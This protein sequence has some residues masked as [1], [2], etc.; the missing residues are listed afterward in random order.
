[1]ICYDD[2]SDEHEL[3]MVG[4][5]D[6]KQFQ[7]TPDGAPRYQRI[8]SV[9]EAAIDRG[10]FRSGDRL[11]TVRE[12]AGQLEVST[13]SVAV[14]YDLLARRGRVQA[15]VG[16][17]TFVSRALDSD[18]LPWPGE[19]ST[20]EEQPRRGVPRSRTLLMA[21]WRR[22]ALRT[23][24]RLRA[25][26]P[27]ALICTSS[28]PDPTLLPTEVLKSAF[29]SVIDRLQPVD[30]QYAGPEVHPD[31][32]RALL[33]HLERDGVPVGPDEMVIM[34]AT[35]QVLT[36]ALRIASTL[37]DSREL[38][39][40]VEEPGH[41][42]MFDTIER[43]GHRMIG[44]DVDAE[45]A[46]PASLESALARGA[47]AVLLTPRAAN[48]MGATWT[49]RR[50]AALAD[51]LAEYPRVLILEDDHFAGIA[52]SAPGSLIQDRRLEERT[53][54]IRSFSKSMGPDLRMSVVA[55]R[56]RLRASLRDAK[57]VTDGWCPQLNQ[58]AVAAALE[59]PALQVAFDRARLAYAERRDAATQAMETRLPAG[60]VV[61]AADGVNLWVRLP[62]GCDPLDVMHNAAEL[63]VL[64]SNGEAFY[65]RP[66][67]GNAVRLSISWID[68]EEAR[69]AGELL[70]SAALTHDELP[71]SIAH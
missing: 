50:R 1:M 15:Q 55:A 40:A 6:P 36:L 66:G 9:I 4:T 71:I 17:G 24:D 39:V 22:R 67:R 33:P 19:S 7:D 30:L 2:A 64:V 52:N 11:P 10:D 18:A 54:Y 47:A 8:A 42:T 63:G 58:R 37:V 34:T 13:T 43:L 3:N 26:N 21:S 29:R 14:A 41:H 45:G 5:F 38:S 70:A 28:W 61:R 44:V 56:S 69:R 20:I 32:A 27:N 53:I 31:L 59:D 25:L 35:R 49:Q 16:R 46:V 51:V 65:V 23:G 48:P 68:R 57:I 62:D 12:L 60:S